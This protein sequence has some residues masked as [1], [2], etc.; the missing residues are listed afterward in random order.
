MGNLRECARTFVRRNELIQQ[1]LRSRNLIE[2]LDDLDIVHRQKTI[3]V[4]DCTLDVFTSFERT[5]I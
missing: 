5:S 2:Q 1:E 3:E 4:C